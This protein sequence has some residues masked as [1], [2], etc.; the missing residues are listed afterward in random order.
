MNFL[1]DRCPWALGGILLGLV[2]VGLQWLA[3]LSVGMT[4]AYASWFEW[5]QNPSGRIPWRLYFFCGVAL[6][7]FTFSRMTGFQPTFALG[8]FDQKIG[9]SILTKA[10][11]LPLAGV[12]IGFG[13]RLSGGCTSGHGLCGISRGSKAGILATITFFAT[14]AIVAQLV[15]YLGAHQ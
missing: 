12:F 14:A 2:V 4:G 15:I 8:S 6:G 13:T 5:F 10:W 1:I 11:V 9:A 7:A 3:N